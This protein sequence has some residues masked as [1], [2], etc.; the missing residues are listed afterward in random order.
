[1]EKLEHP[2]VI[3]EWVNALLGPLV[4]AVAGR[5][6]F[7]LVRARSDSAVPGHG[8]AH[9]RRFDDFVAHRPFAP[10][11]RESRDAPDHRRGR[12]R[13]DCRPA[14]GVDRAD[15]AQVPAAHRHARHL[16]PVREL[17]GARAGPDGADEQHQRDAR[18]RDHDVGLLPFPRHQRAGDR[19]L[20][21]AFLGAARR[22][23]VDRRRCT[24]R[25]RSSA[26]RR[27]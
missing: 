6:G 27:A 20:H 12:R 17:H 5:L 15:R 22:P 8:D 10:E 4:R 25:S 9:R 11:R 16:H 14:R 21:Q 23:L 26:I 19:Q 1:M 2:L 24:C 18:L 3:V 13:R 7:H